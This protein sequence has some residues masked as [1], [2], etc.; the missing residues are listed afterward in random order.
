MVKFDFRLT[1]KTL[2]YWVD[3]ITALWDSYVCEFCPKYSEILIFRNDRSPRNISYLLQI[4]EVE[5][6]SLGVYCYSKV[7]MVLAGIYL[8]SRM[9]VQEKKEETPW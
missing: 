5:C 9:V 3:M 8:M 6:L 7:S 2:S 4:L 1:M